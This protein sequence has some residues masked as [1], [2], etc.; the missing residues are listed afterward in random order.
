MLNEAKNI[1]D[2]ITKSQE[3][4]NNN[5][6]ESQTPENVNKNKAELAQSS[7]IIQHS[8]PKPEHPQPESQRPSTQAAKPTE[9]SVRSSTGKPAVAA[10]AGEKPSTVWKDGKADDDEEEEEEGYEEGEED[11]WEWDYGETWEEGDKEEGTSINGEKKQPTNSCSEEAVSVEAECAATA[12][13]E[14]PRPPLRSLNPLPPEMIRPVEEHEKSAE[15][16]TTEGNTE[17][18]TGASSNADVEDNDTDGSRY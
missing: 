14:S 12:V 8:D 9:S 6:I 15:R 3:L 11:G 10:R 4:Q 7:V 17:E 13:E 18:E 2:D 16:T 1:K 5:C